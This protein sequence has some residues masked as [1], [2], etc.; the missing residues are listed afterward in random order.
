[1][2]DQ[3]VPGDEMA[4][5]GP[6]LGA[7]RWKSLYKEGDDAKFLRTVEF[8]AAPSIDGFSRVE[9]PQMRPVLSSLKEFG[10]GSKVPMPAG[11]DR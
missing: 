3:V 9:P 6:T 11:S 5:S 7:E 10:A 8:E 2:F 4:M 1:M